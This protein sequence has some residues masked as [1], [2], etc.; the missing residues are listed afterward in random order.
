MATEREAAIVKRVAKGREEDW[1]RRLRNTVRRAEGSKI[2]D[3]P[4]AHITSMSGVDV[5][6]EIRDDPE[7]WDLVERALKDR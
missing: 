4:R 3:E 2:P 6:L 1:Q 7:S 5:D